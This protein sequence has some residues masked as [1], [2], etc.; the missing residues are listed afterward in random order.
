M[1]QNEYLNELNSGHTMHVEAAIDEERLYG[2][3]T[4]S[5]MPLMLISAF[6]E[7]ESVGEYYLFGINGFPDLNVLSSLN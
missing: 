7:Y 1:N 6:D 5:L 3:V 2:P 4:F